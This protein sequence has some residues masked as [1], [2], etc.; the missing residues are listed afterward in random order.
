MIGQKSM[1]FNLMSDYPIIPVSNAIIIRNLF[2]T[3]KHLSAPHD[4]YKKY[5]KNEDPQKCTTAISC[6]ILEDYVK[7]L[8][9]YEEAIDIVPKDEYSLLWINPKHTRHIFHRCPEIL[10]NDYILKGEYKV[11]GKLDKIVEL[12]RENH[13][14]LSW[15]RYKA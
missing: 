9:I 1:V 3:P 11:F 8:E 7:V 6:R 12:L 13:N 10:H 14:A 2:F 5:F 15:H 4:V